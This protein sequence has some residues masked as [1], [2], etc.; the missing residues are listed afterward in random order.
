M[1]EVESECGGNGPG[2]GPDE[3]TV[4]GEDASNT[5]GRYCSCECAAK[6]AGI[7]K[8]IGW[9]CDLCG[10]SSTTPTAAT[11]VAEHLITKHGEHLSVSPEVIRNV[12]LSSVH[13]LCSRVTVPRDQ[14]TLAT[15]G[16]R[17]E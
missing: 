4:C 17:K 5:L 11:D 8:R 2:D 1:T 16:G 15:D 12:G 14:Q 6:A 13:T 3:C 10:F 9:G 7:P